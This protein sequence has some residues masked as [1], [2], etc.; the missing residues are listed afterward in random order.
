MARSLVDLTLDVL[1]EL[2]QFSDE[3]ALRVNKIIDRFNVVRDKDHQIGL[4]QFGMKNISYVRQQ[5]GEQQKNIRETFAAGEE[6]RARE[7]E[8]EGFLANQPVNTL[9]EDGI[10]FN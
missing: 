1:A 5:Y 2:A 9:K 7:E 3:A 4:D 10:G 6:R 8:R